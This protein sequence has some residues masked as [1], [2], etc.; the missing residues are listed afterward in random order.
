MKFWQQ[1]F[2][3]TF[4]FWQHFVPKRGKRDAR[5]FLGH[6]LGH[7]VPRSVDSWCAFGA[8]RGGAPW[9]PSQSRLSFRWECLTKTRPRRR[10]G[11]YRAPLK[12]MMMCRRRTRRFAKNCT[13]S[14]TAVGGQFGRMSHDVRNWHKD[15]CVLVLEKCT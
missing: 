11:G 7:V 3:A 13:V 14:E 5:P 15:V 8:T 1:R 12:V 9:R 2:L 4:S 6:L 10:R